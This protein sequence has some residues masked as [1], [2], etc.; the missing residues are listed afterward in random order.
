MNAWDSESVQSRYGKQTLGF[1][2]N[3][4][5]KTRLQATRVAMAFRHLVLQ[6]NQDADDIQTLE[7]AREKSRHVISQRVHLVDEEWNLL[8]VDP[9][10]GN[11]GIGYARLEVENGQKK[12]WESPRT[13]DLL[14]GRPWVDGLNYAD[15]IDFLRAF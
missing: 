7:K 5:G 13:S 11:A 15:G 6:E 4:G 1:L 9:L 8:H 3:F 14:A 10:S 2:T 12:M